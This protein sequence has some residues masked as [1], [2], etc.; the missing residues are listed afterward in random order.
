MHIYIEQLQRSCYAKMGSSVEK[1]NN[2]ITKESKIMQIKK[3]H[4]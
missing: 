2:K 3:I 1:S 4:T